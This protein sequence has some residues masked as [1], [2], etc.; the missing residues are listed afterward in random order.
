MPYVFEKKYAVI[1]ITE[2]GITRVFSDYHSTED[3]ALEAI[4]FDFNGGK[5]RRDIN[6]ESVYIVK[7]IQPYWRDDPDE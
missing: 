6:T 7:Q 4:D 2:D 3:E 5:Y 1:G